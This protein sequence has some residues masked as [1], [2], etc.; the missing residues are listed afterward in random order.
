MM[1]LGMCWNTSTLE[2]PKYLDVFNIFWAHFLSYYM[3]SAC[4]E[5][6]LF[7]RAV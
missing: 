4:M 2:E 3:S 7:L 5:V 6:E 1:G